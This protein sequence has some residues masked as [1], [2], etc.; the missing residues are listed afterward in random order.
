[1]TGSQRSA[2]TDLVAGVEVLDDGWY[3]SHGSRHQG[4][5]D[6]PVVELAIEQILKSLDE[7][8]QLRFISEL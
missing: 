1:M 3:E 8:G 2:A 7:H 4:E 6:L 5:I